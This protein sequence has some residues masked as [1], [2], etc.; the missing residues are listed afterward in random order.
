MSKTVL[1]STL[2]IGDKF[3]IA[4]EYSSDCPGVYVIYD[5][6][7]HGWADCVEINSGKDFTFGRA[8]PVVPVKVSL[9]V[10]GK[11]AT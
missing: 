10:E 4:S 7:Q 8:V 11:D 1:V 9:T 3:M 6:D 2:R 5:V